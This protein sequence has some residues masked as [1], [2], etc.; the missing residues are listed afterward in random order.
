MQSRSTLCEYMLQIGC[1]EEQTTEQSETQEKP[2]KLWCT[3]LKMKD[4]PPFLLKLKS[5]TSSLLLLLVHV[6]YN[7]DNIVYLEL[8]VECNN[9]QDW[10]LRIMKEIEQ[11]LSSKRY[12]LCHILSLNP[13][14]GVLYLR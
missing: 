3:L 4:R 11:T 14:Q 1:P 9:H 10:T 13:G 6:K 7:F 8:Y 5:R 2:T 12:Q